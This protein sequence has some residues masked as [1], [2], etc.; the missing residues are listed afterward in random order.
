MLREGGC[1]GTH[2]VCIKSIIHPIPLA[3]FVFPQEKLLSPR[4]V[5]GLMKYCSSGKIS[6]LTHFL[7]EA[8]QNF[9][10]KYIPF[11][12]QHV[13][14]AKFRKLVLSITISFAIVNLCVICLKFPLLNTA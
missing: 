1:I 11:P 6:S 12:A 4:C 14:N 9:L 3:V 10:H 7:N 5:T 13:L 8:S 2:S